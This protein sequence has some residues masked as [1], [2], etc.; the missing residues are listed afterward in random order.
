[1]AAP[2]AAPRCGL[3]PR[4][5]LGVQSRGAWPANCRRSAVR[6]SAVQDHLACRVVRLGAAGT[7]PLRH[8]LRRLPSGDDKVTHLAVRHP[9]LPPRDAKRRSSEAPTPGTS[10]LHRCFEPGVI[11]VSN[12]A[13]RIPFEQTF[14]RLSTRRRDQ[15][16]TESGA[17]ERLS[18][19][20][21]RVTAQDFQK[22][23]NSDGMS[24][25]GTSSD[26]SSDVSSDN[27][28]SA[29]RM[30]PT[31]GEGSRWPRQTARKH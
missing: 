10:R 22:S 3:L 7:R 16:S 12:P 14:G 27:M 31:N 18:V 26:V 13:C 5:G 8:A 19:L 9:R 4:V 24:S 11:G 29:R 2:A 6:R 17:T 21:L 28:S 1:M 15:L 23:A 30:G 25:D 20:L